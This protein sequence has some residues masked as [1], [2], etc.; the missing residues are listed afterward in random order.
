MASSPAPSRSQQPAAL[1][2]FAPAE[3]R[4]TPLSL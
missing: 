1:K 3:T 2:Y 4:S